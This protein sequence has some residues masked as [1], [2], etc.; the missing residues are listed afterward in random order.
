MRIAKNDTV[1]AIWLKLSKMLRFIVSST[2]FIVTGALGRCCQES[3]AKCQDLYVCGDC[4]L[5]RAAR[6]TDQRIESQ[7]YHE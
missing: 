6:V 3:S 4:R 7:R 5:L 2:V 1:H